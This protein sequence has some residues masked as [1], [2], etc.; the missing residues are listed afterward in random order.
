MSQPKI[1]ITN[2]RRFDKKL[3]DFKFQGKVLVN[4]AVT[5]LEMK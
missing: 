3:T 2:I 1:K 5:P 4:H